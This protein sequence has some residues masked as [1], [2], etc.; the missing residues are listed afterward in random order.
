MGVVAYKRSRL[1][2]S[3]FF[4]FTRLDHTLAERF[5][6][7]MCNFHQFPFKDTHRRKKLQGDKTI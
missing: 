3:I 7:I 4:Q 5:V 6:G 1:F 2:F